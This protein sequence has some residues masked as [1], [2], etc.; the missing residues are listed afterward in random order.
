MGFPPSWQPLRRLHLDDRRRRRAALVAE[1]QLQRGLATGRGWAWTEHAR[2][3]TR[4]AAAAFGLKAG[5]ACGCHRQGCDTCV[6]TGG[7]GSPS[8]T[9]CWPFGWC[10]PRIQGAGAGIAGPPPAPPPQQ[11]TTEIV[12]MHAHNFVDIDIDCTFFIANPSTAS[13][14]SAERIDLLLE[15]PATEPALVA[16]VLMGNWSG[17]TSWD[18]PAGINAVSAAALDRSAEAA[19]YFYP[20]YFI[21]MERFD[22]YD[23]GDLLYRLDMDGFVGIGELYVFGHGYDYVDFSPRFLSIFAFAV[24]REV[25]VAVHWDLSTTDWTDTSAPDTSNPSTEDRNW[26]RL[27]T[28]LDRF[29]GTETEPALKLILCHCG[30]GPDT[31]V[32][33]ETVDFWSEIGLWRKWTNRI[34][35]LLRNYPKVWF[36]L[37]GLQIGTD[38][39]NRI[40]RLFDTYGVPTKLGTWLLAKMVELGP[41][42]EAY[43]K[44]FLVGTDCNNRSGPD[45]GP[46]GEWGS[47]SAAESLAMYQTFLSL[48]SLTDEQ[49]RMVLADNAWEALFGDG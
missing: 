47:E 34:D 32:A 28:L 39:S 26:E 11:A 4:A 35:H 44:R 37:A 30:L 36:D 1:R 16:T 22:D 45:P 6:A 41:D 13:N 17:G 38:S 33:D 23:M 10:I 49:I 21:P 20:F 3:S 25:P 24:Q 29:P 5:W 19:T 7:C 15:M 14:V 46:A 12:D 43:A 9:T 40:W 31:D 18:E 2:M 48:G 8:C 42:G 27:L